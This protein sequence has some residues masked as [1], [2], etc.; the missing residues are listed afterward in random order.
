MVI[1]I[2][3]F[4]FFFDICALCDICLKKKKNIKED[5]IFEVT[6]KSKRMIKKRKRKIDEEK[7]SMIKI[8]SDKKEKEKKEKKIEEE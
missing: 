4:D 7:N 5:E 6:K 8:E 3:K 2:M 1:L